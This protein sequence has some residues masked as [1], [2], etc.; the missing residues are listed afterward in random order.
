MIRAAKFVTNAVD[1]FT[2]VSI[3]FDLGQTYSS[4]LHDLRH[5]DPDTILIEDISDSA[6]AFLAVQVA[7]TGRKVLCSVDSP[8]SLSG[9]EQLRAQ[10][11]PSF[12][13]GKALR[14]VLTQYKIRRICQQCRVETPP[15][16]EDLDQVRREFGDEISLSGYTS[17]GCDTCGNSGFRGF[18]MVYEFLPITEEIREAVMN[19]VDSP[20]L[21]QLAYPNGRSRL[22]DAGLNRVDRGIITLDDFRTKIL[23]R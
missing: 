20:V 21:R 2:Q 16:E 1:E 8:D 12:L 6:A 18:T 3:R 22:I 13:I 11:V 23:H 5:H 15:S 10:G 4:A 14:R 9:L 7:A 17:T 19:T